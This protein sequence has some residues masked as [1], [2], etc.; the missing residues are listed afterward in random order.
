MSSDEFT[1]RPE[2]RSA[3]LEAARKLFEHADYHDVGM[4]EVA[5]QAGVSRQAVYLHFGSKA[6]LLTAVVQHVNEANRMGE[7]LAEVAHAP[8]GLDAMDLWVDISAQVTPSVLPLAARLD[9]ARRV[10][11]AAAAVWNSQMD[12]RRRWCARIIR[13]LEREGR[14]AQEW[15]VESAADTLWAL[16]LP[17]VFEDL[18]HERGWSSRRYAR[19]LQQLLRQALVRHA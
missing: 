8:S 11:P 2:T 14:L 1:G 16:T 17:R 3:I 7:R 15:S 12:D 10:A 19:N 13:R 18:V 4:E 6:N 5:R 9:T